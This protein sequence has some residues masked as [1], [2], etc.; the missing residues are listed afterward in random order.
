MADVRLSQK[1]WGNAAYRLADGTLNDGE[2]PMPATIAVRDLSHYIAKI[3]SLF[4]DWEFGPG[5]I[6]FRGVS[7]ASYRLIPRVTRLAI[8]DE[9]TL[10]QDF[11]I[12]Y[13]SIYGQR[14]EDSWEMYALMQHHGLPT[15]LLDWTKS[16]L[17]ALFFAIEGAD[18]NASPVVWAMDP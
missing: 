15:R 3:S 9:D 2:K 12:H 7:H 10:I 14:L 1:T 11:I 8:D 16:P 17:V 5:C 13:Q 6:W 18:R 4:E